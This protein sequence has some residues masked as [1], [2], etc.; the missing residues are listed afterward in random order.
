MISKQKR[1]G[2]TLL[3]YIYHSM[4]ADVSSSSFKSKK[5][6]KRFF[7]ACA[8]EMSIFFRE[9]EDGSTHIKKCPLETLL[10]LILVKFGELGNGS[11][12]S[13]VLMYTYCRFYLL[14]TI[15]Q[16]DP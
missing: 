15:G 4:W 5:N 13:Y 12:E 6:C 10:K 11:T 3:K 16:K 2:S 7:L 8:T 9:K 1:G 14:L